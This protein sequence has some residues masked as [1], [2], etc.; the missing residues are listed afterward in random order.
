MLLCWN[1]INMRYGLFISGALFVFCTVCTGNETKTSPNQALQGQFLIGAGV[2]VKEEAYTGIDLKVYPLPFIS[3]IG[4]K[5]S[6]Q[7]T[8]FRYSLTGEDNFSVNTILKLRTEGYDADDSSALDGMSD[9]DASLDA[10]L[11]LTVSGKWGSLGTDLLTDAAGRHK[12]QEIRLT[13]SRQFRELGGGIE[14]LGVGPFAGISWRSSSLND[15]YYG[16]RYGEVRPG[17][18][19][20]DS[21]DSTDFFAGIRLDYRLNEKWTLFTMFQTQ[22]LGSEITDSPIVDRHHMSSFIAGLVYR[23]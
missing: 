3:Y 12:G 14:N 10:G 5:W 20:Y 17:R 16:V 4:Q 2:L 6:L 7:G 15:Y 8:Q 11:G 18:P 9:R 13:Y 1:F 23:L 19:A 21:S 22:W